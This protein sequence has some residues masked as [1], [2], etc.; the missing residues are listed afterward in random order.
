[1]KIKFVLLF[2]LFVSLF[3]IPVYGYDGVIS[4]S[5]YS[6]VYNHNFELSF[7]EISDID[8]Y[9]HFEESMD[10]NDIKYIYPLSLT[11]MSGESRRYT[12][13]ITAMNEV[14]IIETRTIE[15]IV[16]KDI[17]DPPVL[18]NKDG[19]Y[20]SSISMK[21]VEN[22]ADIYYSMQNSG[23]NT[24]D[25]WHGE[26][27][28]IQQTKSVNT[29]FIK[30]Y[31]E[32]S[33]GNRSSVLVSSFTILPAIEEHLSLE[34][35]SPV[36]GVFLNNQIIYI[37]T[38][39][40]KWIRYS[41]NDVD[42]VSRGTSYINPVILKM[43]GNYELKI[44][45]QP[46]HSNK[47]LTKK[48]VFSIIDN[49][50]I[51]INKKS[52]IYTEDISLQ[53]DN[54]IM[55]YNLDER[56]VILWD[57]VLPDTLN[58]IPVP[59]VVKYIS[60]RVSDLL[61]EGE[62]RY[63]FILDKRI[64]A[65]P[66]ISV[67][68][69]SPISSSTEVRILG[70]P[71]S[72]I[73]YTIDGS[74][75]DH[76]SSYYRRPFN[77][78]IP[79]NRSSGSMLIKAR[80]YFSDKSS[81][82]V[83]SKLLTYDLKKPEKPEE[84][85]I[86]SVTIDKISFS[87]KNN[88]SNRII[89][90]VTYDGSEPEDPSSKSF[91]GKQ[92]MVLENPY[93]MET[94][95]L[96]KV[97]FIDRAGNISLPKMLNLLK[98][99]TVPPDAPGIIFN[100]EIITLSANETIYYK[101][102]NNNNIEIREYQLYE[103]PFVPGLEDPGYMGFIV[104]CYS[105]DENSNKSSIAVFEDIKKDIRTPVLPYYSGI[106]NDGIYNNPRTLK[107]HSSDDIKIYYTI[108]S[109]SSIPEDPVRGNSSI[110]DEY[111]YFDCPVNEKRHFIV[112][113]LAS[114]DN[115][116]ILFAPEL[117]SFTI[118]RILPKVPVI[119][120]IIDG[121]RYNDDV[122]VS[123]D[124]EED[125]VWILIKDQIELEELN[126]SYF[127]AD[128]ILLKNDYI[129][130]H[131]ENTKRDYQIA[132]ISI[133]NAGNTNISSEIISFSIDKILPQ[134]PII[135]I[136]NSSGELIIISMIS[137]DLDQI[138]YEI[139]YNGIYPENPTK[140]SLHYQ[141]PLQIDNIYANSI[142][143]SARTID[144]AGNLSDSAT[145]RKINFTNSDFQVPV[146]NI[147]KLNSTEN[148][149]SFSSVSGMK[150]YLKEND[151]S[152]MEF[153][154]PVIIDLR[155]RNIVDLFYYSMDNFGNKSSVAVSRIEKISSSGDIITGIKNNKI[156]NTGKVVWKSNE[157]RTVRYEVA[158]DGEQ[159]DKVTI[160]SPELTEP[161]VFDS[162]EGETLRVSMNVKEFI[163]NVQV[164]EKYDSNFSFIID[165]SKPYIPLIKGVQHNSFYQN[166]RL[167]EISSQEL[168]Y[169]KISSGSNNFGTNNFTLYD[170]A[171]EILV[172]EGKYK[173]F[174]LEFYSKDSAG[175]LSDVKIVE[176][177]IDKANIY[178]SSTGEDS[179]D[180]TRLKPF[181]TLERAL[182]Y[183]SQTKRKVINLTEGEFI[184][185]SILEFENDTIIYGGLSP[186]EWKDGSGQTIINISRRL[187]GNL[188][189]VNIYSGNI[190]FNRITLSN[191]NL[192][193]P[194]ITMSGGTLLLSD[195]KLFHTNGEAPVSLEIKNAD[196]TLKDTELIFGSVSNGNLINTKNSTILLEN[197]DIKGTG[198]SGVL[199]ILSL[200]K[201]KAFI[202]NSKIIPSQAKKIEVISS[203]NS[204]LIINDTY[205]D[206]GAAG[207][208]SNLFV[209]RKSDMIMKDSEIGSYINSRIFS[210][211]D[212]IE[213]TIK[214]A[215]CSFNLK[216]NSGISFIRMLNSNFDLSNTKISTDSTVEFISLL[217]GNASII[218]FMNNK[219][220]TKST[221]I[222][223]GF[224]LS[225]SVSV[226]KNNR[227]HFGGG[228]TVFIAF[229]FQRPLSIEF[230]LN[231][232]ISSNIS[233]NSSENQEAFNINGVKGSIFINKNNIYGWKSVLRHN[234]LLLRSVEE[235]N[236]YR[237]FMNI[238]K[239]N[240][241]QENQ[242]GL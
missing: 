110:I 90:T 197:T 156:Y 227:M 159:P 195:V 14:E 145:V 26:T 126:F 113:L 49:K 192:N 39:G 168:I 55:N 178:V 38:T 165:K 41:F 136:D 65:A 209:L 207:I 51:I 32:D 103:S 148:I 58:L 175:N 137:E 105:I 149:V 226:F 183:I 112:K 232:L 68:S 228:T 233:W 116:Q 82:I 72:E 42:P 235:L 45:A 211:F 15:Y 11:A 79:K 109:D 119:T 130:E 157:S 59:G 180:G 224:E 208:Y 223:T 153:I 186:D 75:P 123:I 242:D 71:G 31:C 18:N 86:T 122:I 117:I 203:I 19:F 33:A 108:S 124:T 218:N 160:F 46:L 151:G 22:K 63:F 36:E 76:Y 44:A 100:D 196:L 52:G 231:T 84:V 104:L 181:R 57:T 216:A 199:T 202:N 229:S 215:N 236:S 62:F 73:Y 139:T 25:L 200:D 56:E 128:G 102:G 10:K 118:D 210:G 78:E 164:L 120:S 12:L 214:V 91:T 238:P 135:N 147:G 60:L 50:D 138:L 191:I 206:T 35:L 194:M 29:E 189:M 114:Y 188:S 83:T 40:Y 43:A 34:V 97:S 219:V 81:S 193:A 21:F 134:P 198:N 143:I 240:Y 158:I 77:M 187:S 121:N 28:N 234:D 129:I 87:I 47:I 155:N 96:F 142:Y 190:T 16:D 150:I 225:N 140:T 220:S 237:G 5:H 53:F 64:P 152:F 23:Q 106:S 173:K 24:F 20:N 185:E 170:K 3:L 176:F 154:D 166:N 98:S 172:N 99:D 17:P 48:I 7:A 201:T 9:F 8:I 179:N 241:S 80:A 177:V 127:E 88:F 111:L 184:L 239:G 94:D 70:V 217:K 93:G 69:Y 54:N 4:P 141:L 205:F 67:G 85:D 27:I 144:E 213:T 169:Y 30:S 146:I 230:I 131:E 132:A 66:L 92:N 115:D 171:I 204:K 37:D 222:F 2:L 167:I 161:I 6:G 163:K 95:V 182:E 174:N 89:Y 107:F 61:E 162:V 13:V 212:I 125:E 221:D 1:M 101:V 133:D 74:T